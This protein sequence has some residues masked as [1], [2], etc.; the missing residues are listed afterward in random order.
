MPVCDAPVASED[1]ADFITRYGARSADEIYRLAMTQCVDFVNQDYAIVYARLNLV[2]PI[3]ISR[4][5]YTAIPKLYGLLDTTALENSGIV[6]ALEQPALGA[7]GRGVLIGIID[8]GIDYTNPLFRLPD[9]SSRILGIWDQTIDSGQEARPS[10]GF[11][12]PP[13]YGTFYTKEQIDLALISD[14]P[15]EVVPS[16]DT[17]GH[18]TFMAGV[19]A[20]SRTLA[21]T[22]FSGAAPEASLAVVKLKPAKQYLRDFFLI[23]QGVPAFQENDIMMGVRY[24]LEQAYKFRMPLVIYLGVGTNQ[25]NHDG[26]SPLGTQ[27]QQIGGLVGLSTVVGAGNEVG[28][29]HHFFANMTADQEFEDVELRVGEGETGFSLELW[30]RAPE[31]YTVGLLSPAGERIDRIP[32]AI[33]SESRIPFRLDS[34]VVTVNYRSTEVGTGSQLILMRFETPTPGIWHIRVYPSFSID[35]QFHMWLPMHGFLS[36]D[37]IFLRPNPDTTITE[38]GNAP[39]LITV[40]TYDH[41]TDSIYIHSSRGYTRHGLIKPELA[42]P[43]VE[44]QGPALSG[45]AGEQPRFTRRSGSSVAAA[46]TAGA[47]ADI[48]AWGIVNGNE[49]NLDGSAV[50]SILTRGADRNP[51]LSYPNREWGYGTLNLYQSFQRTRE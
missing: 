33:G 18:G 29:H 32:I 37:T 36:D 25:G 11:L 43:G 40:S 27:L 12:T 23:R 13:L 21:P 16:R 50:S 51:A 44:V 24:L 30:A 41:L 22:S 38:P 15:Y 39:L 5:T 42:A 46:I 3:S 7:A 49:P 14:D 2:E 20:G 10:R 31:L 9:G 28:Y 6:R 45:P 1:Y 4:Y 8:T 17:N 48:F 19:A 34:T 47:I 26:T 35:G